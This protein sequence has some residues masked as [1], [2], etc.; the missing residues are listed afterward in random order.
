MTHLFG[1]RQ[2]PEETLRL[3]KR[4]INKAVR[5]IE[6]EKTRMD[7]QEQNVLIDIKKAAKL[8]QLVNIIT[9]NSRIF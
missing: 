4:A 5:E 1:S 6:R 2:T 8:G 7:R 9:N 3:H